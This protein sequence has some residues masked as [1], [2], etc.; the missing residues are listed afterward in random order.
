M[1]QRSQLLLKWEEFF[2]RHSTDIADMEINITTKKPRVFV[3]SKEIVDLEEDDEESINKGR[4]T[5]VEEEHN[6]RSQ[7][8]SNSERSTSQLDMVETN[9]EHVIMFQKFTL[10]QAKSSQF[11][12]KEEL[13]KHFTKE[14]NKSANENYKLMQ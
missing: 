2:E 11:H 4:F 14:R 6:D 7:S 10:D 1:E 5:I 13:V 3:Q 12:S 8:M 9:K